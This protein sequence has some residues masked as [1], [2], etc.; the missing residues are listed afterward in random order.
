MWVAMHKHMEGTLGISLY[1]YL[2]FKL[3]K[4]YVLLSLM[5]SLQKNQRT[6][7]RNRFCPVGVGRGGTMYTHVSKCK[8]DKIKER[9]K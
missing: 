1:S 2:Y 7:G 4:C 8:I 5:F 6:R 9:K 3:A